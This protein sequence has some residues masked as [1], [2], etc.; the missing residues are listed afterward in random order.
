[1][2][3]LRILLKILKSMTNSPKMD[4]SSPGLWAEFSKVGDLNS[5]RVLSNMAQA[6]RPI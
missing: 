5:F 2:Q 1:M 4:S 6:C 3:Y